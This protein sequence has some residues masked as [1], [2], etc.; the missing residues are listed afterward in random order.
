MTRKWYQN[1]EMGGTKITFEDPGRKG[2]RFWNGGKWNNFIEPLLPKDRRTFVEIGCNAGLFLKMATDAGFENVIGIEAKGQIMAQAER[3]REYSGGTYKL[4]KQHVGTNFTLDQ[5]PLAD[6]VL[7][8]NVHYYFSVPVFSKLVDGLKNRTLYCLVVA[9]R[10]RKLSGN[11]V[12]DLSSVRGY[13]RDWREMKVIE[14]LEE[15]GDPAPR[16]GMYGVSFKGNLDVWDVESTFSMWRRG[17]ARG[18]WYDHSALEPALQEFF[19]MV[20]AGEVFN[21][22]ETL[23]YRYWT[24]KNPRRSREWIR[25]K[26]IYKKGLA[27][28]IQ[29]NG[30]KEPL[31]YDQKGKLLD[32]IHRLAIAKELGYKHILVRRL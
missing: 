25:E 11:A 28:D 9:G 15:K 1:V 17:T 30:M 24:E 2:S 20:L 5:L 6:V 32:G 12:Y 14:G 21:V 3:F 31:F 23:Y 27:E 4:I 29:A 10:A 16:V 22:E 8:A 13:F 7:L 26:L 19:G 18:K